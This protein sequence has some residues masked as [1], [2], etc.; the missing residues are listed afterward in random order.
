[1][2]LLSLTIAPSIII[3]IYLINS[4]KYPEPKEK[5]IHAFLLGLA[6][7][8]PAGIA[9]DMLIHNWKGIGLSNAI[10]MSFLSAA[11]VEEGLKFLMLTKFIS[12]FKDYDEMVDGI[13]YCICLSLGF[14]TLENFYYVYSLFD[15]SYQIAILRAFTAVPA[16]AMFGGMMGIFYSLHLAAKNNQDK[17]NYLTLALVVPVIL[18]GFYNFFIEE[19]FILSIIIVIVGT[20]YVF[21]EFKKWNGKKSFKI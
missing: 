14:A 5:I 8:I 13:V 2:Y 4:D 1:M 18:H 15:G 11:P 17:K 19:F 16:H 3:I 10:S 9:N 12:K 21:K 7:T 20:I 6:I